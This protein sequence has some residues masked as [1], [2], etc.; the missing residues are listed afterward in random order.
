MVERHRS[1][2]DTPSSLSCADLDVVNDDVAPFARTLAERNVEVDVIIPVYSLLLYYEWI[3][4]Y[5]RLSVNGASFMN[6]QLLVR[7]CV[8]TALDKIPNVR[9]FAFDNLPGLADDMRNYR[10]PGHLYNDAVIRYI[11]RSIAAGTNRL[12]REN[13]EA[14]IAKLHHH[15]VNYQVTDSQVW[16]AQPE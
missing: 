12:T 10:D 6:D 8:I 5:E 2:I 16:Q 14:E 15:I 13:V 1:D 7:R 3:D 11:L 4:R 9:I